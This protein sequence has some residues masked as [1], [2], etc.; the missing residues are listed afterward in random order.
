MNRPSNSNPIPNIRYIADYDP[1]DAKEHMKKYEINDGGGRSYMFVSIS[2]GDSH[3][4]LIK[5]TF[6]KVEE[7]REGYA[8]AGTNWSASKRFR[9][10]KQVLSGKASTAYDTIVDRDYSLAA[11]KTEANYLELKRKILTQLSV[12]RSTHI[13]H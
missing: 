9:E 12:L 10:L 8:D 1:K 3:E 2:F 4:F 5:E 13:S 7:V 11:D 6:E